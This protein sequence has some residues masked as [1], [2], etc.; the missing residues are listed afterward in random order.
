MGVLDT[1]FYTFKAKDD[2]VVPKLDEIQ[3]KTDKLKEATKQTGQS[4]TEFGGE[5]TEAI[6]KILPG[7]DKVVNTLGRI[8]KALRDA[9][10][11]ASTPT[12]ADRVGGSGA[13]G[14]GGG[15][16]GS[17]G[18]SG[19]GGGGPV[20]RPPPLPGAAGG[21]SEAASLVAMGALAVGATVA[22]IGIAALAKAA[23]EGAAELV[24]SRKI[25][26]QAGINSTQQAAAEQFS[27]SLR[28]DKGAIS[29]AILEISRTTQAGWV[30]SREFGNI[31]G[32][33]NEQTQ[34]LKRHGI[35]T[36]S[37]G[38]LRN[39]AAIF[40][41]ISVKMQKMP[42][43]A[44]IAFGQFFGMTKDL[45]TALKESGQSFNEYAQSH[46][47]EI[48]V[49]AKAIDY[50]RAYEKAQQGLNNV[51]DD[52]RVKIGGKVIP[53]VTDLL[54]WI[55]KVTDELGHL[56]DAFQGFWDTIRDIGDKVNNWVQDTVKDKV[57]DDVATA[58]G[59]GR[60][61]GG[62]FGG[63][64]N[65]PGQRAA[66]KADAAD[67]VGL[68]GKLL[69][70]LILPGYGVKDNP[71]TKKVGG[72]YD[73]TV[74]YWA[75]Q[76]KNLKQTREQEDKDRADYLK[77][78]TQ[79]TSDNAMAAKTQLEAA[80]LMKVV[81]AKFGLSLE[82]YMA[83][84]AASSGK[85]GGLAASGGIDNAGF[86]AAYSK[87]VG[88]YATPEVA[89]AMY[90]QGAPMMAAVPQQYAQGLGVTPLGVPKHAIGLAKQGLSDTSGAIGS[91]SG[92]SGGKVIKVDV[93]TGPITIHTPSSDPQ[94]INRAVGDGLS[95]QIKYAVNRL[96]D[97]QIA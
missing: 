46:R 83:V 96:N 91:G 3:K 28:M 34:L 80:N 10:R 39:S 61:I 7:A 79:P 94:A 36:S 50:A 11:S 63:E 59:I 74:N 71:V 73:E 44:A 43:D 62:W 8:G 33:G 76:R 97:G 51:W 25:A 64:G 45:A 54:E 47:R 4:F 93:Q 12:A 84:W 57:S 1:F 68:F 66:D 27:K 14:T 15:G 9:R 18:G 92:D 89:R 13:P 21:A 69:A 37:G 53:L 2:G 41:D 56:A 67:K 42:K 5:A 55:L 87:T 95:D 60:T 17:G 24:N 30:K 77:K 72:T 38:K 19:G 29:A 40:D 81:T 65:K 48:E 22:A 26:Q 20:V 16:G 32:L 82:Q 70:P 35:A 90:F 88:Q 49:Q 75:D 85:G 86:R 52:F 23:Q 31:F 6:N 58:K 78:L